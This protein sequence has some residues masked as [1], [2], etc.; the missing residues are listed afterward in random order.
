VHGGDTRAESAG[1]RQMPQATS[2]PYWSTRRAA[3]YVA[4][5][6]TTGSRVCWYPAFASYNIFRVAYWP[7]RAVDGRI[8]YF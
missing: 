6:V 5:Q 8:P 4:C 3:A 7:F 2:A 1:S